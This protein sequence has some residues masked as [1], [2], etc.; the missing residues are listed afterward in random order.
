MKCWLYIANNRFLYVI[1]EH[2]DCLLKIEAYL[3]DQTKIMQNLG[4]EF[5]ASVDLG[6]K[7]RNIKLHNFITI[8]SRLDDQSH[9]GHVGE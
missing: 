9:S 4:N 6:V 5:L 2:L 1:N 8:Y 3:V 7:E